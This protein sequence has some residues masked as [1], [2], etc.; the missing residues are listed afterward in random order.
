MYLYGQDMPNAHSLDDLGRLSITYITW[1]NLLR[2]G[3]I[4]L[5]ELHIT[6]YFNITIGLVAVSIG[7]KVF[8]ITIK[9]SYVDLVSN[10]L[11]IYFFFLTMNFHPKTRKYMTLGLLSLMS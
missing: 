5:E 2:L 11:S 4:I 6:R 3:A 9:I 10:L 8:R 1:N 7:S